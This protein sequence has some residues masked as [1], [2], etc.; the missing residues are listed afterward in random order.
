MTS[1]D[2]VSVIIP[3]YNAEDF[4]EETVQSVLQQ[5]YNKLELIIVND[6]STDSTPGILERLKKSDDRIKIISK[7]NSGVCDARNKGIEESKGWFL[8]FLDAD[9]LWSDTFLQNCISLFNSDETIKAIYTKGQLIN[10]K[11]ERLDSFIEANTIN[12]VM[13]VLKWEKGFVATPSCT[14]FRLP[15][16]ENIEKWD[17]DFST[18]ADQD[19]FMRIAAKHPII[20]IDKVL[21]YYRVHDNNMHQNIDVMEKDHIKVFQK[22]KKM[23][24]FKSFWIEQKCFSNLYWILAGSWWK[25][26]NNKSRGIYFVILALFANPFSI[27]RFFK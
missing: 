13:D 16:P 7:Y 1:K 21:F 15:A 4:I 9:D 5:T 17:V 18:G 25:D 23:R 2:L 12:S 8:I 11:S 6:G 26:G 27:I 20:A 10:S 24:F 19:Y 14:I 22:A 3:V